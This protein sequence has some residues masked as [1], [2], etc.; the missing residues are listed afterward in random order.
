M[1]A[2]ACL[3]GD[4]MFGDFYEQAKLIHALNRYKDKDGKPWC[5]APNAKACFKAKQ[6]KPYQVAL[7]NIVDIKCGDAFNI[8]KSAD[9]T[10]YSWGLVKYEV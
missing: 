9:G 10:T 1:C 2:E 4:R 7:S 6:T 5:D 3:H 8:A